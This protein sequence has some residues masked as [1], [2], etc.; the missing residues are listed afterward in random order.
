V[1]I[2]P[3]LPRLSAVLSNNHGAAPRQA[4]CCSPRG[5]LLYRR[6]SANARTKHI[7]AAG[8]IPDAPKDD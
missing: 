6:Y 1:V 7:E 5:R 4:A 8:Q 2:R 3:P